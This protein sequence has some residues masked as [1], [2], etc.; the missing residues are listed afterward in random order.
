[1]E[2]TPLRGR[3]RRNL[4]PRFMPKVLGQIVLTWGTGRAYEISEAQSSRDGARTRLEHADERTGG[5]RVVE[6]VGSRSRSFE[7]PWHKGLLRRAPYASMMRGGRTRVF[8]MAG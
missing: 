2:R 3:S 5:R 1:M 6:S 4:V 8:C 7:R